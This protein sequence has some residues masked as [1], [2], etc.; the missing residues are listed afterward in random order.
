VVVYEDF[1]ENYEETALGVLRHVGV[2]EPESAHFE[3]RMQRQT[4]DVNRAWARRFSEL[5]LNTDPDLAT[6]EIL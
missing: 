6:A 2:E 1:V 4:D 3:R 5:K